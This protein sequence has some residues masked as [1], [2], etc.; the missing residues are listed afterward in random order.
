[1]GFPDCGHTYVFNSHGFLTV[2]DRAGF[3]AGVR[4]GVRGFAGPPIAALSV[5]LVA[6]QLMN[7]REVRSR[8]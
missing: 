4:I 5:I 6:Y 7:R 2:T 8:L 1:L 3:L